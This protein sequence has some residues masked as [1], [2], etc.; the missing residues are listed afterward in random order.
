MKAKLI[1]AVIIGLTTLGGGLFAGETAPSSAAP[2][3]VKVAPIRGMDQPPEVLHRVAPDY[4]IALRERGI[5]GVA[6]VDILIDS[7][8]RVIEATAVRATLPEFAAKAE[9]AALQWTFRPAEAD[10]KKITSR[11]RVPFEFTMPQVAA[12]ERR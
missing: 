3:A 11:V 9:K 8:G 12:L 4:P 1:P 2:S 6:S 5:Q 10:G 7:T